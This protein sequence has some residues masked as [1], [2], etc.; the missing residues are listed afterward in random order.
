[1]ADIVNFR[2]ASLLKR[3]LVFKTL[4]SGLSIQITY[5]VF[6]VCMF[7]CVCVCLW[8]CVLNI[9]LILV[10]IGVKWVYRIFILKEVLVRIKLEEYAKI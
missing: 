5:S 2:V 10:N 1:M 6:G 8:V 4:Q 7:V 3:I 9:V